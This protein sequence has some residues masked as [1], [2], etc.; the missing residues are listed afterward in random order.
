MHKKKANITIRTL[1]NIL[2]MQMNTEYHQI[3]KKVLL[4]HR[5]NESIEV[6]QYRFSACQEISEEKYLNLSFSKREGCCLYEKQR[7]FLPGLK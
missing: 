4:R 5:D 6:V 3:S 7:T 2:Y 1:E